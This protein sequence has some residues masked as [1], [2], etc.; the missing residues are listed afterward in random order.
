M[1]QFMTLLA[2]GLHQR[3]DL[4]SYLDIMRRSSSARSRKKKDDC[5]FNLRKEVLVSVFSSILDLP[6][7]SNI[8]G[9]NSPTLFEKK[10]L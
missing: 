9:H 4:F 6:S 8:M 3:L 5:I 10:K 2:L 7:L 1:T